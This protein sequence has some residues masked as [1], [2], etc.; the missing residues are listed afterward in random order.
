[1][2]K[3]KIGLGV[4]VAAVL[5]G[6]FFFSTAHAQ[7]PDYTDWEGTWFK[8][9]M[10]IK[11]YEK[12]PAP[13]PAWLPVN[14]RLTAFVNIGTYSDPPGSIEGDETFDAVIHYNDDDTGWK[15][16]LVTL[17]RVHGNPL[18]ILIWSQT[19]TG[20]IATGSGERVAFV[21]RITGKMDKTGT[22]LQTGT[23]K[24][25]AGSLIEL[26]PIDPEGPLYQAS[27]ITM[28]GNLIIPSTFCKSTMNQ[29]YPPCWR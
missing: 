15:Q 23:F 29:Q 17:N 24:S 4:F 16:L 11:G 19:D 7:G 18:D 3:V 20:T 9:N 22:F 12:N 2:K 8:I 27:G 28:T 1:M 14:G 5:I 13:T 25:L 6:S 26:A 21:A 10:V